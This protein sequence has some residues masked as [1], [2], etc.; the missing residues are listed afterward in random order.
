[1]K[2]VLLA[3]GYATR[4]QPLSLRLPKVLLP[5]AGK[6]VI[7]YLVE[8]LKDAGVT[9]IIVSLNRQQKAIKEA[10][11]NGKKY[12]LKVSYCFEET[13]GE[14]D[15]LGAIGA[16]Q[17]VAEKK[18]LNEECILIGSDNFVYGLDLRR[19]KHSH[20]KKKPHAT[21]A[22]F[23][24]QKPEDV[25]HFGVALVDKKGKITAFQE[26]PRVQDAV[27]KLASTAV[28]HLSQGFFSTHL[29][30]YV[31]ERKRKG[32]RADRVGDLWQNLVNK[33]ELHGFVFEGVWGDIGT[34]ETYVQTNKLAMNFVVRDVKSK[35]AGIM[36]GKQLRI[37][38]R[39]KFGN[40]AVIKSPVIIEDNCV[41]GKDAVIG[42]YTHLMK[43]CSIGTKSVVSGCIVFEG[44]QVGED[45]HARDSVIDKGARVR[46]NARI[47]D[48]SLLGHDCVIG[49]NAR[50]FSRTKV[51]PKLHLSDEAVLEGTIKT[52]GQG[53]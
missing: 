18:G 44:V 29:P 10:L 21:I 7:E 51:W 27:S 14:K 45:V 15:K 31:R 52:K 12:G 2:A 38:K 50:V 4:L 30:E 3:G 11:G 34:T 1:M 37:G 47:D 23:N 13:R 19:L 24:L 39:V 25:E 35:P 9:E 43:G 28:Y 48:Y 53:D 40:G 8:M 26:K 46:D 36:A 41:V 42:P 16:M 20:K 33:A 32:V 5:V 17:Y 22:L 6:P 49:R